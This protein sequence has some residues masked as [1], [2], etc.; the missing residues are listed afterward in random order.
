MTSPHVTNPIIFT[1]KVGKKTVDGHAKNLSAS[2]D[3]EHGRVDGTDSYYI[4]YST[5]NYG[6]GV[7]STR[8]T[9][10]DNQTNVNFK[11]S[12]RSTQ[13]WDKIGITLLEHSN[14]RGTGVTC[15]YSESDITTS[16]PVGHI[17]GAKSFIVMKG[18]WALY[19]GKHNGGTRITINGRT[20]FGPGCRID[21]MEH[22]SDLIQS[23]QYLRSH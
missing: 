10:V 23:I 6:E 14:Y 17:Q 9:I 19:T 7:S 20:E 3:Y 8:S 12:A 2:E 1:G 15:T 21:H 16:F 18:V 13:G 11:F 5:T 4:V 22:D